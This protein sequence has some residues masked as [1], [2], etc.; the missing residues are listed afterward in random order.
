MS[1][2]LL[3]L[4]LVAGSHPQ[5]TADERLEPL[6]TL[7]GEHLW[8]PPASAAA[9]RERAQELRTQILVAAGLFPLREREP[10][11]PTIH[12]RIERQG[13][14]VERVFFASLPGYTVTGSL[15]RP[16][17]DG[18]FAG[19]LSPHGH[20]QDGRFSERSA[21]DARLTPRASEKSSVT[22]VSSLI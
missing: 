16:H 5:E 2:S 1:F 3:A 13:Y 18:P 11:R 19:V 14:T 6:V 12:G 4:V 20:W 7:D 9:W 17:G 21:A 22:R 8:T 15:Y 10:V